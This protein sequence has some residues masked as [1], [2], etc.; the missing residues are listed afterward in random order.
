MKMIIKIIRL[1]TFYIK[2]LELHM[3][4]RSRGVVIHSSTII[5]GSC[6]ILEDVEIGSETII[7][8]SYLDGRGKLKIGNR[9]VC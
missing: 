2:Q 1:L 7:E 6:K 5:K 8:N 3:K 4:L 9:C